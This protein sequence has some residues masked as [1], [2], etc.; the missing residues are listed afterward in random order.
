MTGRMTTGIKWDWRGWGVFI[1]EFMSGDMN[2]VMSMLF[3]LELSIVST[4]KCVITLEY[5]CTG[6][7]VHTLHKCAFTRVFFCA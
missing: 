4:F 5:A 2:M 6:T 1:Y 7:I 3:C